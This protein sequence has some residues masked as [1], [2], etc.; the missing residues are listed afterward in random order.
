MYQETTSS[1][2]INLDPA[3]QELLNQV[4]VLTTA[5]KTIEDSL[6]YLR[7]DTL[8]NKVRLWLD[9]TKKVEEKKEPQSG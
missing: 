7:K 2:V 6:V 1:G 4:A 9:T 3:L 5:L 8:Q